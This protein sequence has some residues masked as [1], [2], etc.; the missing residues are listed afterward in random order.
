M[1]AAEYKNAQG[2]A[3]QIFVEHASVTKKNLTTGK[4]VMSTGLTHEAAVREVRKIIAKD[5]PIEITYLNG[6]LSETEVAGLKACLS[7]DI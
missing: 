1:L 4:T 7:R 3:V 2:D 5:M 6:Q